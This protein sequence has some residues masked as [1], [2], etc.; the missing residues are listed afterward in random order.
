MNSRK[1]LNRIA[2]G[3]SGIL[4]SAMVLTSCATKSNKIEAAYVSTVGYQSYSCDQ[5][6]AEA[7][8]VSSR[9]AEL[10]GQQNQRAKKD[11]LVVGVSLVLFW[12]AALLVKGDNASAAEISRMKGEMNAIEEV[13]KQKNCGFVF[14]TE[15]QKPA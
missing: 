11:A 4:F 12:P 5:L 15:G 8:R 13:S 2:I 3:I 14:V 10:A 7:Q 1:E 6:G 9:A